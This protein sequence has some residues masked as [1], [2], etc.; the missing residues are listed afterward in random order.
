MNINKYQQLSININI[1]IYKKATNINKYQ[2]ISTNIK[3]H[4]QSILADINENL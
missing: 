2:Q 3:K 4:Q 1:Q